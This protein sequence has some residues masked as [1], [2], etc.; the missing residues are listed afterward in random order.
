MIVIL[1]HGDNFKILAIL[2]D[3]KPDLKAAF[4]SKSWCVGTAS[5]CSCSILPSPLDTAVFKFIIT[6][7]PH[8]TAYRWCWSNVS[9]HAVWYVH[10]VSIT[11]HS[12]QVHI[13]WLLL[14]IRQSFGIYLQ[15]SRTL[16]QGKLW[17]I[18]G[19]LR[20]TYTG[21]LL[22]IGQRV[23]VVLHIYSSP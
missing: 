13:S 10:R 23:Y 11:V 17:L 7:S 9:W 20:L 18:K 6:A 8:W 1:I 15:Q 19:S 16:S 2:C 4:T 22:G 5:S 21:D 12:S 14:P 3:S